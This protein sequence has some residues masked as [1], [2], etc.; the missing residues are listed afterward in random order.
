MSVGGMEEREMVVMEKQLLPAAC[1]LAKLLEGRL[2]R[3]SGRGQV[4]H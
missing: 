2:A 4:W 1:P 3:G